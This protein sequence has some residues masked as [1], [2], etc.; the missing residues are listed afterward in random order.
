MKAEDSTSDKPTSSP[1]AAESSTPAEPSNETLQ[2][3]SR[4][5]PVQINHITFPA[6]GRYQP[7]RVVSTQPAAQRRNYRTPISATEKYAGGGGILMLIDQQPNEEPD[8]VELTTAPVVVAAPEEQSVPA[9]QSDAQ[10][11]LD[12]NAPEA[13][14]PAPFEVNSH[15]VPG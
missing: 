2:N 1:T 15:K 6:E 9:V 14:P 10:L 4:V 8:Y 13:S 12:P 7:A 5:T 3:F 11:G